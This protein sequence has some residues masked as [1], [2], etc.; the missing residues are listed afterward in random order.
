[1]KLHHLCAGPV[2]YLLVRPRLVS[3]ARLRKW[4]CG[5]RGLRVGVNARE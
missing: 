4:L 1:M 5:A 3:A 2:I